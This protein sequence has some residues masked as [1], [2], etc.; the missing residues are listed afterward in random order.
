MVAYTSPCFCWISGSPFVAEA[1][2]ASLKMP[3]DGVLTGLTVLSGTVLIV[4]VAD[5]FCFPPSFCFLFCWKSS[6]LPFTFL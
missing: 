4:V 2:D 1:C 3:D 6:C 5:K